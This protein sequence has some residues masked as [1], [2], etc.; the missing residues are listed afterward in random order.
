MSTSSNIN[1]PTSNSLGRNT[2]NSNLPEACRQGRG[3]IDLITR[4][5]KKTLTAITTGIPSWSARHQ[6]KAMATNVQNLEPKKI[7]KPFAFYSL[8]PES[9]SQTQQHKKVREWLKD[10]HLY[11]VAGIFSWSALGK[12]WISGRV[13]FVAAFYVTISLR[14]S[15][16]GHFSFIS[17]PESYVS[18]ACY[19]LPCKGSQQRL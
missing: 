5:E 4:T 19:I 12:K 7:G 9:A 3:T 16:P 17:F 11:K 8:D 10:P 2:H 18:G 6:L 14:P 1:G 15:Y 13:K